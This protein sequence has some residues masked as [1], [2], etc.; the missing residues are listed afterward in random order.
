MAAH[1]YS[2]ILFRRARQLFPGGVNSPVRAFKAVGGTP[3]F[4]R[5]GNGSH[6]FDVDGNGYIDFVGSWG[7][8]ILGH[9]HPQVTE[10]IVAAVREGISF[11]APTPRESTLAELAQ[12]AFPHIQKIRFVSSGTEAVMSAIRVARAFT[13]RDHIIKFSGCYHGHADSLLVKAGSGLATFGTPSSPGVPPSLAEKTLTARYNNLADV[14][15][16]VAAHADSVACLIVEPIAGN[17]GCVP[18][19][20]GFLAGLREICTRREIVFIIDEV[21]T[22]FRV[23][24]GGAQE[25]YEVRGDLVCLGKIIGGGMPVGAFG[26]KEE[27]MNLLAPEGAVY[28]AGT[29]SGNPVAMAAGIATLKI[30][31]ELKPYRQLEQKG[32]FLTD[33][34]QALIHRYPYLCIQRVGS[35]FCLYFRPAPV[36]SFEDA[37]SSDTKTFARFFHLML[38][39]GIYLPPAQFEACFISTAHE[40]Q[41]L[42][43]FL[44]AAERSFKTLWE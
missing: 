43:H 41:D 18:P 10:A 25:L 24:F 2:E 22:G 3:L 28:Q 14:E 20:P 21:M 23:A 9:C 42:E 16:L 26:G 6:V 1:P 36:R 33:G 29:L 44:D 4:L 19:Q 12:E 11:G 32:A 5:Q 40:Q 13:G 30:L 15:S 38:D 8:L 17:M 34:L 27:I 31:K 7:P 37:I 35:M 39:Q